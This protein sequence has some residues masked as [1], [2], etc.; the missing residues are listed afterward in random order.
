[1]YI[2]S[3][4]NLCILVHLQLVQETENLVALKVFSSWEIQSAPSKIIFDTFTRIPRL[5]IIQNFYNQNLKKV[6]EIEITVKKF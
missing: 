1:M 6:I 5:E 3:S 2:L 4:D